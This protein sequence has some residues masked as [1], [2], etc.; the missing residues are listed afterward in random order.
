MFFRWPFIFSG[1]FRCCNFDFVKEIY[2]LFNKYVFLFFGLGA[3]FFF[4]IQI[5]RNLVFL[6]GVVFVFFLFSLG[7]I[8]FWKFRS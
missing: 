4:T 3:G 5:M 8:A 7:Y 6:G 2:I 1:C